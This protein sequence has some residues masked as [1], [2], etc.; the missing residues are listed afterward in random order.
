MVAYPNDRWEA[1]VD[2]AEVGE[3]F[4]PATGFVTR[5]GYRRYS[6]LLQFSPRPDAHPFIRQL[7]FD[8]AVDVQTDMRNDLLLRNV[9]LTLLQMNLHT[10]DNFSI[11]TSR[12]YERLDEPFDLTDDIVLPMGSEYTYSRYRIWMQTANRRMIAVNG[13]Y[14]SGEF[15]SG[16]RTERVVNLTVRARP[17]LIVGV[18]GEWNSVDLPEGS[19]MTRLYR[20]NAETQFTPYIALVNNVQY[21]SQSAVMGWQSRFRWILTPGNDLYLVYN[22]NWLDDR[23]LDRFST[24]DRRLASKVLYTYRF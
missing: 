9:D 14:D 20:L 10:G 15:Y 17:G 18:S 4:A 1:R 19:F 8:V 7:E 12:K 16:D 13:R 21:D 5:T 22:H 6:P 23:R 2:L 3:N 11:S 24:M